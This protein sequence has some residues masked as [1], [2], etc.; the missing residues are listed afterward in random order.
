MLAS[1]FAGGA[2]AYP[3]CFDNYNNFKKKNIINRNLKSLRLL[4]QSVLINTKVKY[5]LP[6]AGFFKE[7]KKNDMKI[8]KI[9]KK[10][11]ILD[12]EIF[13]KKNK[14]NLLNIDQYQ[15]FEFS[16]DSLK[17]KKTQ[18]IHKR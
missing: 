5:F 18:A 9:N 11:K 10:N 15:I 14:I 1:S 16:D 3:V 17:N 2:S 12:Y 4:N 13:C 8:K 6:Y 7:S